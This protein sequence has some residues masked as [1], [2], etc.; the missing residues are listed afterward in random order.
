M[1]KL[2]ERSSDQVTV[3]VLR[4]LCSECGQAVADDELERLER[5]ESISVRCKACGNQMTIVL[6]DIDALCDRL[7]DG[8]ESTRGTIPIF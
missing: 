4:I 1:A 8:V 7:I 2:V 3:R 5:E 6:S